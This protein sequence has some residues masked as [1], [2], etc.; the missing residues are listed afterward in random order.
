MFLLPALACSR[1]GG[2]EKKRG[3]CCCSVADVEGEREQ[4][5]ERE[6][7]REEC[8]ATENATS[9]HRDYDDDNPG[10]R[11]FPLRGKHLHYF[12]V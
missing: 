12:I 8:P 9:S 3:Q 5:M 7:E 11:T 10:S 2:R 1:F 4:E 6:G